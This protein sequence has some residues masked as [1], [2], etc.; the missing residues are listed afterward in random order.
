VLA[1]NP[2][3]DELLGSEQRFTRW[4]PG[5]LAGRIKGLAAM[6]P[7]ERSTLGQTLHERVA[8]GHSVQ[9]WASGVLEAAGIS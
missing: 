2:I 4:D 7:A 9:S 5:S 6:T 8:Q 3:F 1:S